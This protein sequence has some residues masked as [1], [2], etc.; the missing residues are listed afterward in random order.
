MGTHSHHDHSHSHAQAHGHRHSHGDARSFNTAFAIAVT[1]TLAYTLSEAGYAFYA[2]SLS[3]LADAVHNLGD[4]LGLMLAWIANWLLTIP[5]RK[6][7]SY[8]F[9]RTTIIAALANAFILVATSAVIAYESVYKF[10]HLTAVNETVVIV[11]GIIGVFVNIGASL[12]FMRGARDDINIKG[13]FLHLM[14]DALILVGVVVSA[15]VIRYTDWHWIDPAMGLLIVGIVLW[16]TWELL[17]DSV[18]LLLDAI[19]HYI[20]HMG[21][22]NYLHN[23]P[24]VK[25]VHDLHIWGL[26]TREVALTAHLIMPDTPLTDADYKKINDTLH[27]QFKISHATLQVESGSKEDPCRRS[28]TC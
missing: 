14:A 5:A 18:I 21:V 16:G 22:K 26:S 27:H 19:P 17:R 20:D 1:L 10:F 4:V 11:I 9:R 15:I 12:L 13:A 6:R 25:A 23:L 7:Y 28:E 2:N 24:G 8:G 3:L